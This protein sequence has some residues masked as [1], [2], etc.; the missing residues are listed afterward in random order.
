MTK[1]QKQILDDLSKPGASLRVDSFTKSYYVSL[2]NGQSYK[3]RNFKTYC[4]VRAAAK[5]AVTKKGF[6]S[7]TLT[8]IAPQDNRK[9]Q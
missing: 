5:W 1:A 6:F 4:A 9:T 7:R 2:P 8:L 3:I